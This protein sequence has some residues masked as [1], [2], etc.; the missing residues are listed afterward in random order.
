MSDQP[1]LELNEHLQ[2]ARRGLSGAREQAERERK[3]D[4]PKR[5]RTGVTLTCQSSAH[6]DEQCP[7]VFS[8]CESSAKNKKVGCCHTETSVSVNEILTSPRP[9]PVTS[10]DDV[11]EFWPGASRRSAALF[12][13][14]L[15][16]APASEGAQWL[17]V[18]RKHHEG[19][20]PHVLAHLARPRAHIAP[21]RAPLR[22][23]ASS[24]EASLGKAD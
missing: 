21:P 20:S 19:A 11:D 17:V 2:R 18:G 24:S 16:F 7:T 22:R 4:D 1:G 10:G 12:V 5:R 9:S 8:A 13:Q 6:G 14:Q 23:G 15:G 3:D